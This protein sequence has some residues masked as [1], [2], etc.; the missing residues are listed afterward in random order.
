M[1][2]RLNAQLAEDASRA[3]RGSSPNGSEGI[4]IKPWLEDG[5]TGITFMIPQI[6]IE[7]DYDRKG[8][9]ELQRTLEEEKKRDLEKFPT[10]ERDDNGNR[11]DLSAAPEGE[12]VR[13][14]DYQDDRDEGG[15]GGYYGDHG[16]LYEEEFEDATDDPDVDAP[17][18][19]REEEALRGSI[20]EDGESLQVT[21]QTTPTNEATAK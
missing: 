1:Q 7:E 17:L 9:D 3:T 19:E 10:W 8:S 13:L 18:A 6:N 21:P 2:D 14:D 15:G 4:R 5:R 20:Q 11:I 12:I 16:S